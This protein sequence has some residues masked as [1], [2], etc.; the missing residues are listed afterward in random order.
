[1][2]KILPLSNE[3]VSNVAKIDALCFVGEKWSENLFKEEIGDES[4]YYAVFYDNDK[5][6]GFG[7]YVQILD[8]GHILNIAVLPEYRRKG[9]ASRI[10]S[11]L[12]ENGKSNGIVAFT[13]EVRV[14]NV[15]ARTLYERYGFK[16]VGIRKKFY[17]DKEDAGIYWLYV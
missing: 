3:N 1:M 5:V 10:L 4:K 2:D 12:I 14:G 11:N 8:E 15:P 16:L 9:I 6:V 7:S 13:L 17:P